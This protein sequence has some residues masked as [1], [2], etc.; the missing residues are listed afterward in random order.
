MRK[1]P[2]EDRRVFSPL[3]VLPWLAGLVLA[4]TL[5]WLPVRVSLTQFLY[6]DYFYYLQV[7]EHIIS[8]DG[9][10]FDGQARTNG[11][12]PAWM[13]FMTVVRAVAGHLTAIHLG[14]TIAAILHVGQAVLIY[15]VVAELG[16]RSIAYFAALLYLL[17]YRILATNLCGLETP[18]AA[19]AL[20][21]TILFLVR[22]RDGLETLRDA[23]KLGVLLGLAV[24]ARFD[25]AL[26]AL[27]IGV[28]T[29]LSGAL[30]T[31]AGRADRIRGTLLT[32]AVTGAACGLTLLPWFLWSSSHS[33]VLLPN[34][35]A[36]LAVLNTRD[37]APLSEL[38]RE[39]IFSAA[40]WLSDTAN[41]LG[42][43]PTAAPSGFFAN[44]SALFVVA[45]VLAFAVGL[46]RSLR[47]ERDSRLLFA[48]LLTYAVVHVGY[49]AFTLRAELRYLLPFVCVMIVVGAVLASR[50]MDRA[51]RMRTGLLAV[52]ALLFINGVSSGISAWHQQHAATRT[53]AA[54]GGL[55]D[56]AL[57]IEENTP[58]ETVV[59]AWNAGVLAYF[60]DRKVVNLD[61][62]INDEAIEYNRRRA[63]DDY[64]AKRNIE[65]VADVESQIDSYMEK[66]GRVSPWRDQYERVAR[67]ERVVILER[68]SPDALA[69]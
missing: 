25:L 34:S 22:H 68:R 66:F 9:V 24:W 18:L 33:G 41:A 37:S 62:V 13:A 42:L 26:F 21:G 3:L 59:G 43:W 61:G 19:F 35:R 7:A 48:T 40:W 29:L 20:L 55:L 51:P 36:A 15:L 6:E 65:L 47:T 69:N 38:V 28:W 14:L 30:R 32:S 11:F 12:H 52:G 5:A 16:S 46:W 67:F 49:Y 58:K 45:A 10:T 60:S 63:I 56:A 4:L 54:H 27:F 31:S 1:A 2:V 39:K 57:W 53:H 44:L 23:G 17:N 50:A 8:G 64:I